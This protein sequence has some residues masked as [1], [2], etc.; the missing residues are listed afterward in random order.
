MSHQ[1][2]RL[3]KDGDGIAEGP[4][5]VRGALPGE[6]VDGEVTGNRID[7]PKILTPSSDRVRAPCRHYGS[8]G[9]CALQHSSDAFLENWKADIV[10]SALS[11]HGI[12]AP[13]RQVLTSPAKS[14]RRAIF[15]ARRTKKSAL[16][17]FHMSAS[18]AI[19]DVLDC[20]VILPEIT[21]LLPSLRVLAQHGATRRSELTIHVIWTANGADV[22]VSNARESDLTLFE[23]L[24]GV[25]QDAGFARLSWNGE[26][27]LQRTPPTLHFDG[28]AV[29]PPPGAFLQATEHGERALLAAVTEAVGD[30]RQ[31]ADLFSGCGTF[32]LPL[33]RQ[34]EIFA[35]E[36]APDHIEALHV[37]WKKAEGLKSLRTETR[38]LFRRPLLIEELAAFDA[39][40]I[41]PPRAGAQAQAKELANSSVQRIAAVSCNPTT[42]ARDAAQ[43]ILG[44]YRLLWI[45]VVDQFRWSPHVELVAAFSR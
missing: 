43:L 8:C 20:Q 16:V 13:I 37:A 12:E 31:I 21:S 44:G 29:E 25:A 36:S 7:A 6:L 14:R 45:D 26:L 17:G 28:I 24:A 15:S 2:V 40:V 3:G 11:A 1:I 23:T 35:Y 34:A 38:D 10:R 41:D 33:A 42:F 30:A 5:Y 18:D 9:G 32:S 39:V 22:A 4:I 27:L 19:V